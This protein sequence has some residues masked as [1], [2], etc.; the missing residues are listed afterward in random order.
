[1]IWPANCSQAPS[2][3]RRCRAF[4]RLC[5]RQ[6]ASVEPVKKL[7]AH[8][9][10]SGMASS[11]HSNF[12]RNALVHAYAA[13][14]CPH[15]ARKVFDEIPHSHKDSV[16]WTALMGGFVR[17]GMPAEAL[18]LFLRMREVQVGLDDLTLV[19]LFN[20]G[21]RL[22]DSGIEAQGH[23]LMGKM[24]FGCSVK[25]CNAL[26]D[27]YVKCGLIGE[28]RRV[29]D[30]MG[31]R[32]VVSYTV[33]LGGVVRSEGVSNARA[34]FDAMPER[35]E[36]AWTTMIVAYEE[37]GC[38]MESFNLLA[39]MIF[40]FGMKLNHITLCSLL[41]ACTQSLDVMMGKWLHAYAVKHVAADG[42]VMVDTALVDMYAKCGRL[43]TAVSVF[44]QMPV[45]N[46]VSWNAMLSG[47]AMHGEVK[48]LLDMF[49]RMV[50][51][52]RPDDITLTALLS[53]CSHA[54]LVDQG[55]RYFRSLESEF[56]IRPK[57]EHY[58]C[59]V[60]ILGRAGRLEEAEAVIKE[61]PFR[62]NEFVLGSLL[63]SCSVRG[64]LQLGQRLLEELTEIDPHNTEYHVLL[65]NLH[66]S[67]GRQDNA[68]KLRR[69]L[70]KRGVRKIPGVSSI[71]IDGQFHRFTAGDKTHPETHTLY[72]K[73]DEVIGK[74]RLA[75]Y[76][77]NTVAQ[78]FRGNDNGE[79]DATQ[80]EEKEQALLY[81]SEK[82]AVC[83]GLMRTGAGVPLYIFKNL[84]ICLDC[85]SAL[86][87]MSSL[88]SREI[89]VRDRFRFHSFKRGSCSCS[90]YW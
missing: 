28:A 35:N 64:N 62:P 86:K 41:S 38:T 15:S 17:H 80:D 69:A 7:H 89:V 12:L 45:R 59:M 26:M 36:T 39:G 60:D 10:T 68:S 53:A 47:L 43:A 76:V 79:G 65:A 44:H 27:A 85:H 50:H 37:N 54:G 78:A 33:I 49:P 58:A 32:S 56:A 77:P 42:R 74:L 66:S 72:K 22:G 29:F 23:G 34:M 18:R 40:D 46:V 6:A 9:I 24:G 67:T 73:L 19:C 14:A 83:F 81:H 48:T 21:A 5:A 55:Y 87:I 75:G 8:L 1:M 4:L 52:A 82:L 16:D 57:M 2:L 51:D 13:S 70:R 90:D 61:M 25:G 88:Y 84:R 31:E 11:S 20:A 30:E 63:G 71:Q 3:V